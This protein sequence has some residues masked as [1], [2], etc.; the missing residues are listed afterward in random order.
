[1]FNDKVINIF[2]VLLQFFPVS[3]IIKYNSEKQYHKSLKN[4]TLSAKTNEFPAI[5]AFTF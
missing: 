5:Y 4:L 2:V 1:M 3:K